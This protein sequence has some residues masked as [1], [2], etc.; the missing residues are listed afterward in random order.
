MRAV[1]L[2]V[3]DAELVLQ[4]ALRSGAIIRDAL[5]R[6]LEGRRVATFF[7]PFGHIW[8]VIERVAEG[9]RKAA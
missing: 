2:E 5:Q 1:N 7:D 8:G 9:R 3:G 6:D 4:R